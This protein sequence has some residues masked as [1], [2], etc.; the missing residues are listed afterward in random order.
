MVFSAKRAVLQLLALAP[1]PLIAGLVLWRGM[2]TKPPPTPSLAVRAQHTAKQA[3]RGA[4][5]AEPIPATIAGWKRGKITRYDKKTLF[6]RING[7]APAYIAAGFRQLLAAELSQPAGKEN[8]SID[9]YQ[10]GDAKQARALYD[11]ERGPLDEQKKALAVGDAGH[12]SEGSVVFVQGAAYVKLAAF[13]PAG[14]K[15][16]PEVARALAKALAASKRSTK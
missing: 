11:K 9:L 10:L 16:L 7:A 12:Q 8:V 4:A 2:G 15:I 13:E 14:Q 3:G 5:K 6:D 1:I